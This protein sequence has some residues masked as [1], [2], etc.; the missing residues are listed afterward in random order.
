M[1]SKILFILLLLSGSGLCI[2]ACVQRKLA[3]P[4]DTALLTD[5]DTGDA[6]E[7]GAIKSILS[8]D[9]HFKILY[10]QS[11]RN[12]ADSM[13]IWY[14]D[15]QH[16]KIGGTDGTDQYGTFVPEYMEKV[17][18]NVYAVEGR[19]GSMGCYSQY[20]WLVRCDSGK[21]RINELVKRG[22]NCEA[23][24]TGY[25]TAANT[26]RLIMQVEPIFPS[27][28]E[29]VNPKVRTAEDSAYEAAQEHGEECSGSCQ[30]NGKEISGEVINYTGQYKFHPYHCTPNNWL[31]LMK[32]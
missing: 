25:D 10:G 11:V 8:D 22:D 7:N 26:V 19:C 15:K 27:L 18:K 31:I 30:L 9:K 32:Y 20:L 4:Y 17:E 12:V 23:M 13:D 2:T 28:E 29:R 14:D 3:V 16:L 21:I 5:E 1:K 24:T 6:G